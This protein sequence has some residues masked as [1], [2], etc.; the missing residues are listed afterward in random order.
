M[1]NPFTSPTRRARR[2]HSKQVPIDRCQ[3]ACIVTASTIAEQRTVEPT[4]RSMPPVMITDVMPSAIIAVER[5]VAGDVVEVLRRR[6][7]I[8]QDRSEIDARRDNRDEHPERLAAEQQTIDPL[9]VCIADGVVRVVSRS[10][11]RGLH[12]TLFDCAG[13]EAGNLFGG[14]LGDPFIGHLGAAPKHDDAVADGEDVGNT[15]ADQDDRDALVAQTAGCGST[16]QRPAER[17]IAAV[18]SSISTILALERRCARWRRPAADRPT[19][20]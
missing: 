3:P 13:D 15:M 16:L 18:G 20:A 6:N 17:G 10:S 7:A 14:A 2:E 9:F 1:R 11:Y 4:L 12:Y 19:C 5:E 8:L